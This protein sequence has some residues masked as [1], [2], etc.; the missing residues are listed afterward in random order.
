MA[1][2][3]LVAV[4]FDDASRRAVD[5]AKSL[6][7]PLGAS[8]ALVHVYHVPVYTYPSLDPTILPGFHAELTAA[9]RAS[10][11]ELA[12]AVGVPDAVLREGDPA[13]EILAE[14]R[15][16]GATMIVMG[17]HGRRGIAHALLGSV[18]EQIIRRS[19]VP[20]L[21]V[22]GGVEPPKAA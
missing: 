3:L 18:A 21:T 10:L 5:L 17:T 19:P 6:A 11:S 9:A 20:V 7:G 22:R 2:S 4:D 1:T 15:E 12:A 8:I 16:R 14:A 13:P